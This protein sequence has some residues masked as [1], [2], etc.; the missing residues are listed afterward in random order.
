MDGER[1]AA[2]FDVPASIAGLDQPGTFAN[3]AEYLA[4]VRSAL[5]SAQAEVER[6]EAIET[7]A[8]EAAGELEAQRFRE[9]LERDGAKIGEKGEGDVAPPPPPRRR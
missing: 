1:I 6:L 7:E 2:L 8:I 9:Q 5:T 3:G 4:A